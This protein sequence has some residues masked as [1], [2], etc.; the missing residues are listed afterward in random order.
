VL[1]VLFARFLADLDRGATGWIIRGA[2]TDGFL[3]SLLFVPGERLRSD[4]YDPEERSTERPS[5]DSASRP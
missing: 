5:D 2:M 1:E 3:F 4:P